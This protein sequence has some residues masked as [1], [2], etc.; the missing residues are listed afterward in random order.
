M[1]KAYSYAREAELVLAV[2]DG[3][4]PLTEADDPIW[5][6]LS[7]CSGKIIIINNKVDKSLEEN[8]LTEEEIRQEAAKKEV[9]DVY[10]VINLSAKQGQGLKELEEAI[11]NLVFA[12]KINCRESV[13]VNDARQADILRQAM[14][15]LDQTRMTL[16]SGMSED[17]VVIDL[18][19]A[20]EKL[21]EITGDTLDEDIIDEIFSR[22]C[23]G[24]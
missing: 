21:G 16:M 22:F 13:M 4:Q 11:K 17:F 6:L 14:V 18:R 1:E 9:E 8:I 7:Q 12:G 3:S 2:I 19:S 10:Q 23:I 5:H 15:L 24:K 20:W